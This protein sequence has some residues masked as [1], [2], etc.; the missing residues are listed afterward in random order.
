[1]TRP[2]GI[3][4]ACIAGTPDSP[5]TLNDPPFGAAGAGEGPGA[6]TAGALKQSPDWQPAPQ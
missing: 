1:M 3:R 5:T 6:G 2:L 4:A